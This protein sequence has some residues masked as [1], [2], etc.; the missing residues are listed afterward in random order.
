MNPPKLASRHKHFH[1]LVKDQ[2]QFYMAEKAQMIPELGGESL[3]QVG[4]AP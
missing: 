3:K 4:L 1:N 2:E